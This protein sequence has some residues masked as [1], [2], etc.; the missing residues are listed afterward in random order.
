MITKEPNTVE[1]KFIDYGDTAFVTTRNLKSLS[2]ELLQTPQLSFKCSLPIFPV[3]ETWDEEWMTLFKAVADAG[4]EG[5][6]AVH[7][8]SKV[9]DT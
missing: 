8:Y 4:P 1:V 3:E 2:S 9:G 6:T 7:L 5:K